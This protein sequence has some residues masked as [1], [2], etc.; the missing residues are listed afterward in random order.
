MSILLWE[1]AHHHNIDKQFILSLSILE[2]IGI[3]ITLVLKISP[4]FY[5]FNARVHE[6]E[7]M[8]INLTPVLLAAYILAWFRVNVIF[9]LIILR[10]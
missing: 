4:S 2:V 9:L 1:L 5:G 7:L 6:S 10:G 3:I 8:V